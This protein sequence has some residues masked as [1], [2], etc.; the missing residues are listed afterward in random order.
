MAAMSA[1]LYALDNDRVVAGHAHH[2]LNY[3]VSALRSF[4][5]VA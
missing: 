2:P 5:R 4:R 3:P 1:L